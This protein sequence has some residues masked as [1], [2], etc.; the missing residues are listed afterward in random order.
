MRPV[1][2]P[3]SPVSKRKGESWNAAQQYSTQHLCVCGGHSIIT[4]QK[5]QHFF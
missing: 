1:G 3:V 5:I 2:N 4:F